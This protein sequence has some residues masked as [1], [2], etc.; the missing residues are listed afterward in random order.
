MLS[1]VSWRMNV[2]VLALHQWLWVGVFFVPFDVSW[3]GLSLLL[4]VVMTLG[5]EIGHHRYFSHRSFKTNR[6]FQFVLAVWAAASF[7]RSVLWWASM[8]RMHHKHS[9]RAGDPHSPW[10]EANGGLYHAFI[11]WGASRENAQP[12]MAM[13]KDLVKF[14]ELVWVSR[15]HYLVN[16]NLAAL[17]FTLGW[18]GYVGQSGLHAF[19]YLYALPLAFTRTTIGLESTVS[20]GAPYLPGSYKTY[21]TQDRSLNHWWIG[22]ISAGGGFHNNHHR[23]P[24]SARLGLGKWEVDLAFIVICALEKIG[25]VRDVQIPTEQSLRRAA[26]ENYVA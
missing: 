4:S 2:M 15:F 21:D 16:L 26:G 7:Q 9:D 12:H 5:V 25:M 17:C 8:H 23:F 10:R 13:I 6:V 14:P 22:L 18:A 19:V 11:N 20:H 3:L 1:I 24:H